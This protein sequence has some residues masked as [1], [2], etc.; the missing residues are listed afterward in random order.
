M[1]KTKKSKFAL[2]GLTF[3][4]LFGVGLFLQPQTA[5]AGVFGKYGKIVRIIES[6]TETKR[7]CL[8]SLFRRECLISAFNQD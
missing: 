2:L 8:Y 4:L 3:A 7:D 1:K 5:K 6:P